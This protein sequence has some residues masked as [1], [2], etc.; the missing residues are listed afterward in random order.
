M[1]KLSSICLW[2]GVLIASCLISCTNE[3]LVVSESSA[4]G[5]PF[6][7]STLITK[8]VNDGLNTEWV[9][10][11]A[12]NL[13]HFENGSI[14]YQNDGKF[15][16][17]EA[18]TG[19]FSGR[20]SGSLDVEKNYDW[21][22]I[23]PYHSDI[24]TPSKV[25]SEIGCLSESQKQMGNDSK[26]HLSGENCPLYGIAQNIAAADEPAITMKNLS[27][28]VAIEVTNAFDAPLI[29]TNVSFTSSENIVGQFYIDF[30]SGSPVFTDGSDVS[31]TAKL[32]VSD[33][34]VIA[35]GESAKFYLAVKPHVAAKGSMIS[36]SVN[37]VEKTLELTG[38]TEF[39]AGWIKT[40]KYNT[41][42]VAYGLDLGEGYGSGNEGTHANLRFS[43]N[44]TN[45]AK[46][47]AYSAKYDF[48]SMSEITLECL[49]KFN[50]SVPWGDGVGKNFLNQLLGCPDYFGMRLN[51][52][53]DQ[54]GT[55]APTKGKINCQIGSV[56]LN[57][58][59]I[60]LNEWHHVALIFKDGT[61]TVYVDGNAEETNSGCV[62]TINLT[63]A[64]NGEGKYHDFL[65][66]HYGQSRW[67]N[68]SLAEVRVWSVARSAEQLAANP[69]WVPADSEGLLAYWKFSGTTW[70]EIL[71]DYTSN[72]FDLEHLNNSDIIEPNVVVILNN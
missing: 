62:S 41:M 40:L 21:F 35:K 51:H 12:I 57:S 63:N 54:S 70:D 53:D 29:V 11:D 46:G 52:V 58:S 38:D 43:I 30:S 60:T 34:E 28:I 37:G 31:K 7:I 16:V 27:S 8:T 47:Y 25:Y 36:L 32:S 71:K 48:T 50:H 33:G 22:A 20:L 44:N 6:E 39:K 56:E 45:S 13:F 4:L 15:I 26:A 67:L 65:V 24:S 5:I 66:G 42:P 3:K 10:N 23:Y 69:Y 2:G 72:G 55:S 59:E 17:D 18:L 14:N 64:N 9:K 19:K 1:K 61:A 68:G 49:V